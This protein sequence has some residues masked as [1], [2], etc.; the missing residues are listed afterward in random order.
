ML[1]N[2]CYSEFI[3]TLTNIFWWWW[4]CYCCY[5]VIDAFILLYNYSYIYNLIDCIIIICS[6]SRSS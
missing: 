1:L 6:S 2:T 5:F 3:D 4:Y